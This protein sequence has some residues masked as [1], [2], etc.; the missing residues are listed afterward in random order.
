MN[1]IILTAFLLILCCILTAQSL[2]ITDFRRVD[3]D[4]SARVTAP[5][6]DNYGK[7][8]ALLKISTALTGVS[9]TGTG[10]CEVEAK[11]GELWVY[12][13]DGTFNIKVAKEGFERLVYPLPETAISATVYRMKLR[14]DRID[15][16]TVS[17]IT[18]PDD[19]EK[20]LD[21]DLLGT[22]DSYTVAPGEHRLQVKMQGYKSYSTTIIVDE[23]HVLFR[24]IVLP[25]VEPVLFTVRS[26]PQGAGIT[27]DNAPYG[28]TDCQ[29]PLY[30]G[31]YSLRLNLAGYEPWEQEITVTESGGNTVIGNL[32]KATSTLT[33]RISPSDAEVLINNVIETKRTLEKGP[34]AY[35]IEVKKDGYEPETRMITVEKGTPR[36]ETFHLEQQTGR[37]TFTVKPIDAQITLSNGDKWQGGKI[38]TLPVS[39]YTATATCSGYEQAQKTFRITHNA[40]TRVDVVMEKQK[41]GEVGSGAGK[42]SIEMVYVKGGTFQMGSDKGKDDQKPMHRVT[43]SSFNIGKYEVTQKQWMDVMGDNP[44]YWRGYEKPVEKITWYDC[45]NFCNQLSQNEGLTPVYKR[46]GDRITMN[47]DAN[48]YRLPTEAEWEYASRG[49]NKSNGY[50][51][52]GSNVLDDYGW[53]SGNSNMTHE[54]GGKQSNELGIYD[55]SGNI[56]EWC[57]DWYDSKFF[58]KDVTRDP[59]GPVTGLYRVSRGGHWNND[60]RYCEVSFRDSGT[61]STS[62]AEIGFRVVRNASK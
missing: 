20:W 30:P 57:W 31:T 23:K 6:M 62:Y 40:V 11:T 41:A 27:I 42:S 10:L 34:G 49:G 36:T 18:E 24:D 3:S 33:L 32:V 21:G 39:D 56:A 48:G 8:M 17:F 16:L 9:V 28:N 29:V 53:Y 14:G 51:F 54:I 52:S 44:S 2:E 46:T 61:P 38:T 15:K 35:K 60:T 50:K 1:R 59:T 13:S 4:V 43:V 47:I 22:G 5:K 45:I 25:T 12:I 19:A 26:V 37:L 7:P 58:R 55:M